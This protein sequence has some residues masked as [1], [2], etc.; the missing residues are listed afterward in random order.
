M[1]K[2]SV[3]LR[4]VEAAMKK[5]SPEI[6]MSIGVLG[7]IA[8]TVLAVRATPKALSLI[9]E[10][11]K[12]LGKDTL[13]L[14][15]TVSAVWTC[16]IPATAVSIFS[17]ACLVSANSFHIRRNTALAAAYSL[18]ET[19]FAEYRSKTIEAFGSRKDR[20]IRDS[21]AKEKIAN[22]PVGGHRVIFTGRGATLCYDAVSGRY[23]FS[24][25]EKLKKTQNKLNQQMMNRRPMY[26]SLNE[27]YRE[28]GLPPIQ[29]GDDLGWT[30]KKG[31]IDMDFSAH[32]TEDGTPCLVLGY[33]VAPQYGCV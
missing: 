3:I 11:K 24:D 14:M 19:A 20:S 12:E 28:I 13:A 4:S 33:L 9:E 25:I 27:L 10:Q 32:L 23:F 31:L 8:S 29:I 15:E 5:H 26:I 21:V 22:N 7:M 2:L 16:Y 6:L 17:V 1:P 30:F 18:S